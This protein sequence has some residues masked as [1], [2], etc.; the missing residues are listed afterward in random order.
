MKDTTWILFG[1]KAV[2]IL[3][4]AVPG[5]YLQDR[6]YWYQQAKNQLLRNLEDDRNYNVAR[7]IILFIGDGMGMTTVTTAR[8]LRGQKRGQTGEE[9]ELAF[10]KFG[11]IALAKTYNT[12]SQVGD[13]GACATA[14]LCGVKGRF[15]TVGLDDTGTYEKCESSLKAR[16]PCLAD[17]A[18]AEGKATGLVTT[19]RV[20]HATPAAMYG[21]SPSRYWESDSKIPVEDRKL[22]KDIARQLV[23]NDPGRNIN[24]ILGGGRSH[25]LPVKE[26]GS[27]ILSDMGRREDGQNLIDSWQHDKKTRRLKYRYVSN[28]KEFDK[29][30]PRSTD[31]LLGLFNY[32]HM[33]YEADRDAGPEGEPSLA[34]MTKKAIQILQKNARGYFLMVEGGRI[35]HSHHFNN[36][37]RALTD[38]LALEDAVIVALNMTKSDDTLIVVTSDHS[39]VFAFGGNPKR[40]NPILGLDSKLSDVDNMPYTTLLYANGPG[41]KRDSETGRENLTGTNTEEMNYVQQSAV[42]RRWDTHGGEDVP[43]YA[44]GPM[45]HLFR[46]VLEQTYVPHAMAYAACI[47]PQRNDCERRRRQAFQRQVIECPSAHIDDAEQVIM[48]NSVNY[49]TFSVWMICSIMLLQLFLT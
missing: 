12:D 11:Y 1:I 35:D 20:T 21:H 18:Q 49:V 3:L 28:K 2:I 8:I 47:G 7:N 38:T 15:E 33:S 9:N 22:C 10:D 45:S 42:P 41:Y 19:T 43:V 13:S 6:W 37:H 14:L 17:W 5:V 34:E 36:A 30:D 25:F 31:Y 40:G 24:V 27:E 4:T 26:E 46:G 48:A 39:H 32:G 29:V 44:H 23:E 16:I